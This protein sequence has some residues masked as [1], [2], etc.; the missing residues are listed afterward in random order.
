MCGIAGIIRWAGGVEEGA[1]SRLRDT[2]THRGP[3]DAGTWVSSDGVAGLGHR[4]LS[5]LD[6]SALG[7]QPMHDPQGR[8]VIAYNG[9]VYNFVALREQLRAMGISFTSDTDTEV[10]LQA[11]LAWGES[12]VERLEGMFA[13]AIWDARDRSLLLVRDRLGIKPLMYATLPGEGGI[14]FGSEIRAVLACPSVPREL[15]P[16]AGWDF[17]TYGYIPA[18]ATI[19]RAVAKLPPATMMKLTA[20]GSVRQWEYWQPAFESLDDSP[21]TAARK[22]ETLVDQAVAD[23]LVADVP[24]GAY[25][26]GGLDSSIVTQRAAGIFAEGNASTRLGGDALHTFTMGFDV[27][28]HSEL[29]YARIAAQRY[30]TTHAER[31]VSREMAHAA[32]ETIL[33]MFDEPFAASSTIPMTYL[34]EF[35][36][37]HVTVALC[38]EG[39]DETFGGYSWYTWW[40]RF[41]QPSFWQTAAGRFVAQTYE[42]ITGKRKKKWSFPALPP[43]ELYAQLMGAL[44]GGDKAKLFSADLAAE[45]N[46]RDNAATF[47]QYW[48][49]DLPAMARLQYVDLKTFLP[50]L[51]L[52]RADRTSMRVALE[53]R[54]PLLNHRLVEYA[55]GLPQSVRNPA[56]KLKG[57]FK[58]TF[59]PRLPAEI[60]N[61]KKKGFSAPVKQWYT[62]EQLAKLAEAIQVEQP[63]LARDWLSPDLPARARRMTGSRA[64]KLWTFLN[65]LRRNG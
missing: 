18:P 54:V 64:Y 33:D 16:E 20:D 52:A 5:I 58:Q 37:E 31:I 7:H 32:D 9:E 6:L 55:I 65:W 24:T 25:L 42:R 15:S 8:A 44:A 49:D 48:R 46:T 62:G 27:A 40:Q 12:F 45:M 59:S 51:N 23:Y 41:Q 17:F 38:G 10:V 22:L 3:D 50:D 4:R 36:R 53:L 34:A 57:L 47:R 30:G 11:Y 21:E 19:Y 61:R 35:A 14:V 29:D 43:V 60:V 13:I 2:L 39:G 1:V 28:E 26:S 63:D 56:G